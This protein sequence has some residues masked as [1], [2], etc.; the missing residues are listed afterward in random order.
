M[1]GPFVPRVTV[2]VLSYN[3]PR[4]LEQALR[5]ILTQTIPAWG[6]RHRQ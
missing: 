6:H 2:V 4:L 5:S 3:R 1:K